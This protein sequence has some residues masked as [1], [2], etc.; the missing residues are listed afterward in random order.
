MSIKT[1]ELR[2][3]ASTSAEDF[4][5][6]DSPTAGTVRVPLDVAAEYFDGALLQPGTAL[7]AAL[8]SKAIWEMLPNQ[9]LWITGISDM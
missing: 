6:V 4:L 1:N 3:A 7:S 2:Q 8:S 5:L 9:D